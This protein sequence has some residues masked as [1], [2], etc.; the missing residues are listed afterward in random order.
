MRNL[1]L[2]I[3]CSAILC[4]SVALANP[5]GKSDLNGIKPFVGY[6]IG[7]L[8]RTYTK[9]IYNFGGT[10][11][12]PSSTTSFQNGLWGGLEFNF[13]EKLGLRAYANIITTAMPTI[14]DTTTVKSRSQ[15]IFSGN[16]DLVY[17]PT[18][19]IGIFI[20]FGLGDT[21][22]GYVS[23]GTT[24]TSETKN[25]FTMMS[26]FGVQYNIN[27][28]NILELSAILNSQFTFTTTDTITGTQ[29]L[30]LPPSVDVSHSFMAKYAYRF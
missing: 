3:A 20:G 15:W 21:L 14:S 8:A 9:V 12:I 5:T 16:L 10:Y 23:S 27:A 7:T 26:N 6:M 28:N 13:M 11:Y 19:S 2:C 25:Y 4:S 29:K 30:L 18:Q 24:S 22:F 17:R 1:Y